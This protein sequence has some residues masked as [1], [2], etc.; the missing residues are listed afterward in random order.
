MSPPGWT[1]SATDE[2]LL[3]ATIADPLRLGSTTNFALLPLPP[4]GD[5]V[6]VVARDAAG[7][8][9]GIVHS[10]RATPPASAGP[11]GGRQ[12]VLRF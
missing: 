11:G 10:A 7:A 4:P 3:F 1:P 8:V 12:V 5:S 2:A 9:L 6:V